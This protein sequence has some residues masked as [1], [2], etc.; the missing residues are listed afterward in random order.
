M[1]LIED[2]EINN[3]TLAGVWITTGINNQ[4]G[5]VRWGRRGAAKFIFVGGGC[6]HPHLADLMKQVMEDLVRNTLF[7]PI[8]WCRLVNFNWKVFLKH[9]NE[10]NAYMETILKSPSLMFFFA[11]PCA[12]EAHPRSETTGS[13]A[14]NRQNSSTL[15][16]FIN[17]V[18]FSDGNA[19]KCLKDNF[20][21]NCYCLGFA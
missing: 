16:T 20:I 7:Y 5:K 17:R 8:T 3:N 4:T 13:T 14:E 1:G 18:K 10:N 11:F 21:K 12:Q 15:A 2:N 9:C 19:I 6:L